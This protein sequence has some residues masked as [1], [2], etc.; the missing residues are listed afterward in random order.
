MAAILAS[1]AQTGFWL[2][3][4]KELFAYFYMWQTDKYALKYQLF[5]CVRYFFLQLVHTYFIILNCL[6]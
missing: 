2:G 4:D 1:N 3:R 6:E 5:D